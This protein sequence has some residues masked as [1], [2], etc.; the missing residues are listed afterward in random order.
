MMRKLLEPLHR[1]DVFNFMDDILILIVIATETW[2]EQW[3]ALKTKSSSTKTRRSQCG[4]TTIKMLH[5]FQRAEFSW[6]WDC[7]RKTMA[8]SI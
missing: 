8:G 4:G 5:R 3:E 1:D 6:T 7:S 2:E